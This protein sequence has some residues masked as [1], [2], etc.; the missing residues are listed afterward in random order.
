MENTFF[1]H[2]IVKPKNMKLSHCMIGVLLGLPFAVVGQTEKPVDS[3]ITNVT[4]FLAKAQVS[5][6]VKTRLDAGKTN[7]VIKGLTAQVDPQSIQVAGKGSFIILGTSHR[8]NF[9]KTN[10]KKKLNC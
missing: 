2:P 3:K 9:L 5:R 1:W 6:E 8:Q 7:L 4:V 10:C